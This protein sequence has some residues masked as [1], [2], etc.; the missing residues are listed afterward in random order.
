M[1]G[2]RNRLIKK[3][4]PV[5]TSKTNKSQKRLKGKELASFIETH[6]KDFNGDGDKLCIEAGY[7]EYA[8]NGHA[9]CNFKPFVKELSEVMDLVEE[10]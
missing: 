1:T 4:T 7:G 5:N 2:F 8:T 6:R 9:K 10:I 3:S